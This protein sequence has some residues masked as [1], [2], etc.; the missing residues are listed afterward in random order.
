MILST[1]MGK[2]FL[3]V[4]LG[5]GLW[6]QESPVKRAMPEPKN[7]KVLK[8]PKSELI[9]LMRNYS[10]SLGVKCDFC[11]VQGDMASDEKHHKEIARMMIT[12]TQEI[13]AKFGEG[14]TKVG[15]FTCH[16]GVKEPDAINPP[17]RTEGGK[18]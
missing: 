5:A 10:A 18:F 12:M 9:P 11:H 16:R 4:A 13:N 17:P 8:V 6:A 15:C 3:L 14:K 1:L 7:L 2:L